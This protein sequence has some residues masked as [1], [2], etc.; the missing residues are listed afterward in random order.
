MRLHR[1]DY[2]DLMTFGEYHPP[3]FVELFGPLIGLE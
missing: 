2:L 1:D 3:M